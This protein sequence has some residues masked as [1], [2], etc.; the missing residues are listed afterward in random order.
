MSG[1]SRQTAEAEILALSQASDHAGAATRCIELYGREI[2]AFI[3][4]RA[5]GGNRADDV[6]SDTLE[7]LWLSLPTFR[8]ECSARTWFYMLARRS[9]AQDARKAHRQ[10]LKGADSELLSRLIAE[11]RSQTAPYLQ[12]EVKTR[13]RVLREQLSDED[14]TLLILRIDRNLSFTELAQ[15]MNE[16]TTLDEAALK[17][18][19]TRLRKRF[20]LAKDKLSALLVAEGLIE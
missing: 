15:V 8:W 5:R 2:A 7:S 13:A 6:F 17:V 20:Q 12:T 1:E 11:V 18:E 3:H 16:G 4:D 9:L 14:Q 10:P 19:A